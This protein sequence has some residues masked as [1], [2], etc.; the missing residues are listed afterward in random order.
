VITC[1]LGNLASGASVQLKV[2]VI[3]QAAGSIAN[4]VVVATDTHESILGNN[5]DTENTT[6]LALS[7]NLKL[8][9]TDTPDPV[10]AGGVLTYTAHVSNLGPSRAINPSLTMNPAAEVTFL[11]STP[12]CS[13]QGGTVTCPLDEIPSG[14]NVDVVLEMQ[15]SSATFVSSIT[16]SGDVTSAVGDPSTGN[17]HASATTGVYRAAD[18]AIDILDRP[19]PVAPGTYLT[20]TLVYT[21][22]GASDAISLVLTDTLP[23]DVVYI[24]AYSS[25]ACDA[26]HATHF[27]IC[28]PGDLEAGNS[29][30][31]DLV[32]SVNGNVIPPLT[33]KVEIASQTSD[34][35]GNNNTREAATSIDDVD[36][37]LQWIAPEKDESTPYGVIM[38]PGLE[39]TLVV[40]ATDDV[41]IDHVRFTRW[42]HVRNEWVDI[43]I[44]NEVSPDVYQYV[45]VFQSYLELPNGLNQVYAYAYDTAGNWT[46]KRIWFLPHSV[47]LPAIR[48]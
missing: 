42:D 37:L 15:V 45:W 6:V 9:L 11:T 16:S 48:K 46:R 17:N 43:G 24:D 47:L 4:T 5:T 30:Q 41:Q 34:P 28:R 33:N 2:A 7:A 36:P 22:Y 40:T 19:N 35:N 32:V 25:P 31:I 1:S 18:L 14:G 8:T 23:S 44:G 38:R 12:P 13:Q 29:A 21:N 10:V 27:V 20:Y 39:I 26:I 3:P